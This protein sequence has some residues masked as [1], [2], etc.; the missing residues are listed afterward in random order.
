MQHINSTLHRGK[1]LKSPYTK[2][3]YE[4]CDEHYSN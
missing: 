2:H 3:I 1:C 4:F